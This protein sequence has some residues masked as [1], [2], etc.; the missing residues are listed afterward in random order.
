MYYIIN[1]IEHLFWKLP[2]VYSKILPHLALFFFFLL[3]TIYWKND[4]SKKKSLVGEPSKSFYI[5]HT[6]MFQFKNAHIHCKKYNFSTS[7]YKTKVFLNLLFLIS[8]S[9]KYFPFY[10][11]CTTCKRLKMYNLYKQCPNTDFCLMPHTM[12]MYVWVKKNVL[13]SIQNV[14]SLYK[15]G[16]L[17]SCFRTTYAFW[18]RFHWGIFFQTSYHFIQNDL[19]QDFVSLLCLICTKVRTDSQSELHFVQ[20]DQYTSYVH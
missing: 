14:L 16:S 6:V 19:R 15:W 8:N 20:V 7:F 4:R 3:N 11:H 13:T 1:N 12:Y 17:N 9:T 5:P 10:I 18:F 2:K